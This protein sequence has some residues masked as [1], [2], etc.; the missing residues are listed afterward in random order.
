MNSRIY[1]HIL[2]FF[3]EFI[4]VCS[5]KVFFFLFRS[6]IQNNSNES[7]KIKDTSLYKRVMHYSKLGQNRSLSEF[8]N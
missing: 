8:R 2:F 5:Y 4:L 3:N 6:D 7:I 1:L